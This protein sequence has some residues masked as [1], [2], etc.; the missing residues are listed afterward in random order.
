MSESNYISVNQLALNLQKLANKARAYV[1]YFD[2]YFEGEFNRVNIEPLYLGYIDK[3]NKMQEI[4]DI[5]FKYLSAPGH[6]VKNI[7]SDTFCKLLIDTTPS[8]TDSGYEYYKSKAYKQIRQEKLHEK[9]KKL[10]G[11]EDEFDKELL[12]INL[13]I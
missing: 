4:K 7:P 2:R 6:V 13:I 8:K 5:E 10:K 9:L 1:V 12:D 11:I 3:K